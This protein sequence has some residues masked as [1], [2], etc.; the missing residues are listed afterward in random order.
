MSGSTNFLRDTRR[1]ILRAVREQ[2]M[3]R[4]RAMDEYVEALVGVESLKAQ[5]ERAAAK[6]DELRRAARDA[7]NSAAELRSAE[8]IVH[9]QWK[10]I[11]APDPIVEAPSDSADG[12]DANAAEPSDGVEQ[13]HPE[14]DSRQSEAEQ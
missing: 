11:S 3:D 2:S 5:V 6:A 9:E 14:L 10:G 12:P 4:T 13:Y 7:G 1:D 8:R